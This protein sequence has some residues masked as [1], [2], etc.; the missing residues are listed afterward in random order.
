MGFFQ[1]QVDSLIH[2][3]IISS[4]YPVLQVKLPDVTNF[5]I[6]LTKASITDKPVDKAYKIYEQ[7]ASFPGGMSRFYKYVFDNLKFPKEVRNG[8]YNGK[9]IIEFVID[10]TGLIQPDE[11]RIKQGL[12]K[13][14]DEEAIRV[15]RNSPKWNPG[16]QKDKPVRVKMTMPIEF[17][18]N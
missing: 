10:S 3:E 15:F 7:P 14:C 2:I 6:E 18:S 12:C 8:A 9:V 11:V 4:D 16:I 13:T 5:K 1:V 17:R